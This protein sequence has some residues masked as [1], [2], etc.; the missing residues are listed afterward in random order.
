MHI[1]QLKE[2]NLKV[3]YILHEPKFLMMFWRQQNCGDKEKIRLLEDK[4][5]ILGDGLLGREPPAAQEG[6]PGF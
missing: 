2:A 3:G 6:G 1:V 5:S 4:E